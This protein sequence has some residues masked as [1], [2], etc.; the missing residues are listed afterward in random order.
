MS[1]TVC[2]KNYAHNEGPYSLPNMTVPD[3]F[4]FLIR[5][6][7]WDMIYQ[8]HRRTVGRLEQVFKYRPV[9]YDSVQFSMWVPVFWRN[10]LAVSSNWK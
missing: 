10:M 4:L 7:M 8:E 9:D 2:F 5:S 1:I 6:Y 3:M